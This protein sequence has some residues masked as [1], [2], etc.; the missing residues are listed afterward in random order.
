VFI[1]LEGP[2][3]A[4]KTTL[5]SDLR[6]RLVQ[7]GYQVAMTYEP[8][9]TELGR[10]VREILIHGLRPE[11]GH[12][13]TSGTEPGAPGQQGRQTSKMDAPP[14][15]DGEVAPSLLSSRAETL[16]FCAARAQLVDEVI[17]PQLRAGRVVICD[18]YAD[19]TLAYQCFGCGLPLEPVRAVLS[20]ATDGLKPDLTILLDL[21]A[22][23]S[24]ARKHRPGGSAQQD[25]FESQAAEFHARVRQGYLT[26]AAAEPE[27]WVVVDAAAPPEVVAEVAWEQVAQRLAGT[28]EHLRR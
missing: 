1:T 11:T 17:R 18:R 24:L 5:A 3:G 7:A 10:R 14:G 16:L 21:D 13:L 9:G 20:F 4:G 6:A 8:G 27:R 23:A 28:A 15:S 12:G 2:D 25:R 19:S 22:L 26:L